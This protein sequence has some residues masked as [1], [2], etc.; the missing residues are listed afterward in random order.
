MLL[1]RMPAAPGSSPLQRRWDLFTCAALALLAA[2]L[3][4]RSLAAPFHFDDSVNILQN[5]HIRWSHFDLAGAWRAASASANRRPLA[6]FSFA[7][8]YRLHGYSAPGFHAFNLAVHA[9]CSVAVFW[10]TRRLLELHAALPAQLGPRLSESGMRATAALAAALFATHPLQSQSVVY[11]VQRMNSLAALFYLLALL[12]WLGA[13]R[14]PQRRARNLRFAAAALAWLLALAA[15]E[16]AIT[17]PVAI[18]LVEWFFLRDL[19]RDFAR[20]S[21]QIGLPLLGVVAAALYYA[22]FQGPDWGYRKRD[23][24]PH[25]RGLTEL[26]VL[27]FYLSL[28]FA[29]VPARL[30]IHHAFPLSRGWLD[31][32]STLASG[33]LLLAVA[34]AAAA[35]ARRLRWLS[36]GLLWFFLHHAL[37]SSILPLELAYEHRNYLPLAG[38]CGALA[39]ALAWLAQ[40]LALSRALCASAALLLV[41]SLGVATARRVEVWLDSETLWRDAVEKAPD[42][43]RPLHNLGVALAGKRRFG[44]AIAI[45]ERVL[46]SD[47]EHTD[48]RRNLGAALLQQGRAADALPVLEQAQRGEPENAYANAALADA[49]RLLGRPADAEHYYRRALGRHPDA[50]F[51]YG[52]ALVRAEQGEAEEAL[53]WHAMALRILPEF[54]PAAVGRGVLFA[55]LGRTQ[56]AIASFESVLIDWDDPE[57]HS[58]LATALWEVGRYAEALSQ[59]EAAHRGAPH[60]AIGIR[61][62]AWMLATCPSPALRDPARAVALAQALVEAQ[63][64]APEPR[65]LDTLAAARAAAGDTARAA[66]IAERATAAAQAQGEA[67]LAS[68]IAERRER[69]AAGESYSDSGARSALRS[70][71]PP[72][73]AARDASR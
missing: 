40:R 62:L 32:P 19:D 45:Y 47:P 13:R 14:A 66:E 1:H 58:Q 27:V 35:A 36:F 26:R 2:G 7:L 8:N 15:K 73:P 24:G 37:E 67:A 25:E 3:Y 68:A 9:A 56:D 4:A 22:Y 43:T 52:L 33:L 72:S 10:L 17:L 46:R 54:A 60:S 42:E 51:F 6:Y 12:A 31:P 38:L 34:A 28:V 69:Y 20:R 63:T 30:S 71:G 23:F 21:A 16:I 5:P 53:H 41:L 18:W 44:Q 70:P 48:A 65:A 39:W 29:P 64:D 11:V 55:E 49:L 50:Q 57:T 59:A 61:Q